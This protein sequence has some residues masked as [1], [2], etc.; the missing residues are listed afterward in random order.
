MFWFC[1]VGLMLLMLLM[2]LMVLMVLMLIMLI[3]LLMCC[4]NVVVDHAD[5]WLKP[6]SQVKEMNSDGNNGNDV[7][8]A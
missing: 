6:S 5:F 7:M 2:L 1:R 8:M 4:S 3:M